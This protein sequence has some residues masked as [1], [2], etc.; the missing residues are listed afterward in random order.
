MNRP[1]VLRPAGAL[2]LALGLL[3]AAPAAAECLSAQQ[4]RQAVASGD[5]VRLGAVAR[6]V[7]GDIVN[8]QLC[9]QGGRLVYRL[10]VMTAGG[11]VATVVI[12]ART[13]Q[14]LN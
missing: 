3:T 7:R 5:A 9:R 2:L 4:A 10:A 11:S 6:R 12:D 14:P 13:G 8:A 1:S